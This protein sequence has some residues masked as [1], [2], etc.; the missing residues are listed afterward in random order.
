MTDQQFVAAIVNSAAW[1]VAVIIVTGLLRRELLGVIRR[2]QSLEFRGARATFATL[3]GYEQMIASATQDAGFPDTREIVQREVTEFSGVKERAA[4]TPR[5]AVIQAWGL[6]EYELN[7]A[8]DRL[9]PDQPHG[10][11][12]VAGTLQAAWDK[13][14]LLYPAVQEL[15]RLRDY[16]AHAAKPPSGADAAR[17]VSV[18]QDLAT[19]VKTASISQPNENPGGPNDRIPGSE[20]GRSRRSHAAP[21]TSAAV[22]ARRRPANPG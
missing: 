10:W 11:P 6:L 14:P 12:Q 8:A 21:G 5:E 22:D 16:T 19:A 15:R 13:W 17:Y 1:P 7:V 9:A 20:P 18:A 2:L 4:D 3:P